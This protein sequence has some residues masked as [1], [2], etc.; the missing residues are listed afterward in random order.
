MKALDRGRS[1]AR[2]LAGAWRDSPTPIDVSPEELDRLTPIL[3]RQGSGGLAWHRLQRTGLEAGPSPSTLQ[4]AFRYHTL[5]VRLLEEQLRSVVSYLKGRDVEPILM[6]GW[7]LG[8]HYPGP[9][10]RPYGDLDL[11]VHPDQEAET[12][13]ALTDP[14]SPHAPIELH[15]S[16]PMLRDRGFEE[17]WDRSQQEKLLETPI[18][19][20]G[21]E[22]ELRLAALHGL[23]HGLCR[24]LWLCDIGAALEGLPGSFDW[25]YSARG[26]EWLTEGYRCGLL[27]ARELLGISL[28]EAGVPGVLRIPNL[29]EWLPE[30]AFRAFGAKEHYLQVGD[31][32]ELLLNPKRL[33]RAAGLRWANPIEATYRREV[34]WDDSTRL[35]VQLRDYLYRVLG[36]LPRIPSSLRL[37]LRSSRGGKLRLPDV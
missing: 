30:A 18:R 6:K 4:N 33:V 21:P 16:I 15:T 26:E 11:L 9:G 22:D 27:L 19:I 25:E 8:R 34:P 29:P 28:E 7:A 2:I 1:I 24:P 13:A 36:F 5:Q 32:G 3:V 14:E 17:L 12:R 23:N 35:P 31:P 20:L 37:T 10:L